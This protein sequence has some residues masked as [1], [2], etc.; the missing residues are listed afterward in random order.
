MSNPFVQFVVGLLLILGLF[1]R[2]AAALGAL[3]R[4]TIIFG[5]VMEGPLTAPAAM[6][7]A[8]TANFIAMIAVMLFAS[9]GNRWSLEALLFRTRNDPP[10][11]A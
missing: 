7:D 6:R 10:P 3:F 4:L 2:S 8:A 9:A 1:T 11:T 5:H